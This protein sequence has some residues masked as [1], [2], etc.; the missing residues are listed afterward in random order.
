MQIRKATPK[1]IPNIMAIYDHAR[2]YMRENGNDQQWI[3]GYPSRMT[4]EV[5]IAFGRCYLCV[6]EQDAPLAVFC[7][8]VGEDPTYLKI[9]EGEWLND[10]PY[11]VIHRLGV[12]SHRGGVATFCFEW[13][14]AQHANIRVDTHRINIPMQKCLIKNGYTYCGIIYIADGTERLAYQRTGK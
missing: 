12:M 14:A 10:E 13:C 2:N 7:F 11:G 6:D 1:D 8:T 9:Y 4:V 3:N 5:D